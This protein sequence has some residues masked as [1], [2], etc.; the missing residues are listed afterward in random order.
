M[1][2]NVSHV[3][4]NGKTDRLDIFVWNH[5]DD[6]RTWVAPNLSKFIEWWT[7]GTLKV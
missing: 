4:S 1:F 5:E 6:S 3:F 7:N 2:S